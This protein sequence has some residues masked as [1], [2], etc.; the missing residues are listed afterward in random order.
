MSGN[1]ALKE[2]ACRWSKRHEPDSTGVPPLPAMRPVRK[3]RISEN[4]LDVN[5]L[6]SCACDSQQRSSGPSR[7][8]WTLSKPRGIMGA[9]FWRPVMGCVILTSFCGVS[10]AISNLAQAS[11]KTHSP[12]PYRTC[13]TTFGGPPGG[14][15]YA[16]LN[17]TNGLPR[18]G[19]A[20][21]VPDY[22]PEVVRSMFAG[23][24]VWI[25]RSPADG[26]EVDRNLG[27]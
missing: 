18:P 20:A 10:V 13:H 16:T 6:L 4:A 9:P 26:S 19:N 24:E 17:W 8:P 21:C 12:T 15:A 14:S 1:A 2:E 3:T 23:V 22:R 11:T 25:V 5:D 7:F 27:T